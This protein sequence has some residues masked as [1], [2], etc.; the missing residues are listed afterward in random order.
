MLGIN[1]KPFISLDN[2]SSLSDQEWQE[3]YF[4]L[5]LGLAKSP[6]S[7]PHS[8]YPKDHV[9][10]PHHPDLPK[11]QTDVDLDHLNNKQKLL[12]KMLDFRTLFKFL[13]YYGGAYFSE[14]QTLFLT[15]ALDPRS[16]YDNREGS[17]GYTDEAKQHFPKTIRMID[18]LGI[19]ESI[20]RVIVWGQDPYQPVITHKDQLAV[21]AEYFLHINP[22]KNKLF[23]VYDEETDTK[24]HTDQNR[25]IMFNNSDWHGADPQNQFSLT[26]KVSGKIKEEIT[27]DLDY[28]F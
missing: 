5:C 10:W 7:A 9:Y 19:L 24:H 8:Y 4:E 12:V 27:K 25:I 21:K 13:K 22:V 28:G 20:G 17:A 14:N 16:A 26:L 2:Y 18:S 23:F 11:L 15:N 1:S 3:I 6:N